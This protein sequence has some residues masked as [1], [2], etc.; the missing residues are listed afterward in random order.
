[1]ELMRTRKRAKHIRLSEDG[2]FLLEA[3][4]QSTGL[5]DTKVTEICYAMGCLTLRR[6][7]RRA[8]LMLVKNLVQAAMSAEDLR[9]FLN[10]A[11]L[12]EEPTTPPTAPKAKALVKAK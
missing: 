12:P 1:M 2:W 5:T 6:E 10:D 9:K 11:G 7:V 3:A 4:K 8:H